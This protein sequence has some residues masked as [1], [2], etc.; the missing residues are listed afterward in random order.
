MTLIFAFGTSTTYG[1]WDVEGGWVQRLRKYLDQQQLANL[2]LYYVIYNLGVS[3][4]TSQDILERFTFE[5]EQR[6][7]LQDEQEDIIFLF[8]VGVND[9]M[10]DNKTKKHQIPLNTYVKNISAL[11]QQAKKYTSLS[12][13]FFLG[14]KPVDD[15]KVDPIPWKAGCSYLTTAVELYDANCAEVCKKN[16]IPFID[17]YIPF[18]QQRNYSKLLLDGVHPTTEGHKFIFELVKD[19]L[20]QQKVI[21]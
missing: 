3:G 7:K 11:I 14:S 6:T 19:F 20:V 17:I 21:P 2:D 1:A 8:S 15:T 18:K 4:D 13:I 12:K 16:K 9:S 10:F 5:T